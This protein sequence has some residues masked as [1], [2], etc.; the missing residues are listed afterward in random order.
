MVLFFSCLPYVW[1]LLVWGWFVAFIALVWF[2]SMKKV[3]AI[4][5]QDGPLILDADVWKDPSIL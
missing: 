4:K 5:N 3:I 2:V 1:F